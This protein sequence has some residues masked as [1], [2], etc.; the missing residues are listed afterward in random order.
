MLHIIANDYFLTQFLL[1]SVRSHDDISVIIH[2]K[3]ERGLRRSMFKF[4]DAASIRL[5][6]RS[7]IYESN[8]VERLKD[9]DENDSVLFFG[10]EKL[11]E[12]R[13]VRRL[14]RAR[15]VTLFLW[16]PLLNQN[17]IDRHRRVYVEALK[18]LAHL[19]TFDPDDAARFDLQL[20]PQVYRD[21]TSFQQEEVTT[22][23]DVYF[24]GQDKGRLAELLRLERLLQ[25]AGLTTHFHII[26]DN[27]ASY[28]PEDLPHIATKGLSYE[29]NIR[30]IRR[31]RCLL[32]LLQNNQS[33]LS[34][35]CLEAA[36]F[37][38]KLITNN[39]RMEE[40]EL[41]DPARVFL[42]GRD[43]EERLRDFVPLPCPKVSQKVLD[44]HDFRYWCEQFA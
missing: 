9:I 34:M 26:C 14:I 42:I 36:F 29:D 28:A 13:M 11:R 16:N 5:L 23:V 18:E 35:R 24:V 19:C 31:S 12:L 27:S 2:P 15:K 33:G 43:N 8:Y 25:E 37:G 39:L 44:R 30:M 6:G 20:V 32:E 21:V 17:R 10:I 38:K 4:F 3:H 41:Y 1:E 40:S 7:L 22:D